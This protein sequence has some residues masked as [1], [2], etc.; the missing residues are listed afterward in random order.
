[1]GT[2]GEGPEVSASHRVHPQL[3]PHLPTSASSWPLP[4]SPLG[5]HLPQEMR[6]TWGIIAEGPNG[7]SRLGATPKNT[8]SWAAPSS[9]PTS[10]SPSDQALGQPFVQRI[11]RGFVLSGVVVLHL[12]AQ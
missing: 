1:M 10:V 12:P 4:T 8:H 11:V 9:L 5:S 3:R 2:L 6:T 7:T